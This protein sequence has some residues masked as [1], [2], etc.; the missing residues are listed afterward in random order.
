VVLQPLPKCSLLVQN[1][2]SKLC[3]CTARLIA[4]ALAYNS[5][6]HKAMLMLYQC[7]M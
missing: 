1:F 2:A 7:M 5:I 6:L 3:Y 4:S